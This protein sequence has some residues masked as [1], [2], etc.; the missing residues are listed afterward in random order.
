M[1]G[2]IADDCGGLSMMRFLFLIDTI[3]QGHFIGFMLALFI[4]DWQAWVRVRGLKRVYDRL[5]LWLKA[6]FEMMVGAVTEA[7]ICTAIVCLSV[8]LF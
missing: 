3:G 1:D 7:L 8:L 2:S 4:L 5:F 6:E